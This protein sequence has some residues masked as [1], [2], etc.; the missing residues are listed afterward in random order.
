[1]MKKIK[2]ISILYFLF[3]SLTL[4]SQNELP[5]GQ[6]EVI[7]DFEVRLAE[8]KKIR[9]VPEP[10][11]IDTSVRVYEYRL[12]APAPKMEYAIPQLKPLSIEPEQKPAY[13]PL[14]AKAGYGN[15]NS[16]LGLFSYDNTQNESLAWGIDLMH[17]SANNK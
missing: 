16:L 9:I 17:L 6:I 15:P 13:Y 11:V 12:I 4:S 1:M 7:K 14:F 8:A 3:L 2:G 10:L 5:T